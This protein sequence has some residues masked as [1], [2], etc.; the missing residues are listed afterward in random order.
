MMGKKSLTYKDAGVDIER[1]DEIAREVSSLAKRTFGPEVIE[2]PGG[3]AGLFSLAGPSLFTKK[4]RHPV[5]VACSDGVGT[6]LAIAEVLDKHDTV[7]IDLVAM[8]VNDL[9][10][11][12]ATPLFFLDYVAAS[13]LSGS[14]LV[15]VLRG[16]VEG[17]R[18]AGCALLGGETAEMPGFY[19]GE[20]YDL[21]GFAVGIGDHA[22][23]LTGDST[24]PG[25]VVIGVGSSGVHSNG[26]SL[27]RRIVKDAGIALD[28]EMEELGTTVGEELL[29]P[30][31]VYTGLIRS[32]LEQYQVKKVV[33]GIAHITGG[34]LP[35]N[36]VRVVPRSC[37]VRLYSR[38]WKRRP[39][40]DLL[41]KWGGVEDAE[42]YKVFNMG[43]GLV[44]ISAPYYAAAMARRIRK[45]GFGAWKI[46]EVVEGEHEVT[47]G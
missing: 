17:C 2:N 41:K 13:R 27:V 23:L 40:F 5:V 24:A 36:V 42:M 15:E 38:R 19:R 4:M 31:L 34:G 43:I 26:Y 10:C 6:K 11:T 9:A 7:G 28:H 14:K 47:I 29:K 25:D 37:S 46:G 39:I 35:G 30:T 3:F 45:L 33:K 16:V 21:V 44:I 1:G 8:S 18:A 22:K 20:H 32:V 12:G